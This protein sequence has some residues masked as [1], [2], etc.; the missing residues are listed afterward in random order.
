MDDSIGECGGVFHQATK[1]KRLAS[2][3]HVQNKLEISPLKGASNDGQTY[4][5][6]H[7]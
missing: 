6:F 2:Y 7:N 1:Q 4:Q 3:V 5:E